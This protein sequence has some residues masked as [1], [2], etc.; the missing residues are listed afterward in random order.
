MYLSVADRQI[1][2]PKTQVK[3][4]IFYSPRH[5]ALLNW[6]YNRGKSQKCRV[7]IPNTLSAILFYKVN[8]SNKIELYKQSASS[9]TT[10][11]R[12]LWRSVYRIKILHV[13]DILLRMKAQ[14][15]KRDIQHKHHKVD[16]NNTTISKTKFVMANCS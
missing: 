14:N 9:A 8:R 15:T 2:W 12:F 16:S 4:K 1:R 5:H 3:L 7:L 10:Q 13:S 11:C 6:K